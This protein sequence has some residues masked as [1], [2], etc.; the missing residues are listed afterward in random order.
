MI[1]DKTTYSSSE[2]CY[3]S[4][5]CGLL[6]HRWNGINPD[7]D[8]CG[9]TERWAAFVLQNK[10]ITWDEVMNP[11]YRCNHP[12]LLGG[13]VPIFDDFLLSHFLF[14]KKL[15]KVD[16][17]FLHNF[18]SFE[19]VPGFEAKNPTFSWTNNH[20]LHSKHH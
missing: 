16:S 3:G 9:V 17:F 18:I 6:E 7:S 15:D 12:Y 11:I 10:L 13:K 4:T 14:H 19:N 5:I 20:P 8:Y 2:F 1:I